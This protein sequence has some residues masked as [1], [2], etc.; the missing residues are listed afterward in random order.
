MDYRGLNSKTVFDPQPM[1]KIDDIL[2]K[3]GKAKYLTK[4]DLTQ[5]P[6]AEQA[7]PL[8]AFVTPF[9][10][11]QFQV[12]P[13]GMI[14]S[15]ASFVCLMKK[16]LEGKDD[17][18]DSFIDDTIV[19]SDTWSGR[20][21]HVKSILS[22]LRHARLTAKPS[23]SFFAFRQLEFLAHG[24][25]NGEVKPK[26]DKVKAIQDMPVPTTKRK[27]RSL[28][29]FLNF[30]R[31]FIPHFS[32]IASP[33]TDLT[34]KSA[35]NKVIW[36][37][38]HQQ[39]FD[40]LKRV[41]ITYPVLRNPDFEKKIILQTDSSDRG[42]NAV[43]LQEFNCTKLPILFISK[44]LLFR[45]RQ[46]STIEKECLA[47]VRA[48]SQLREYL[49]G[50]Q[51]IIESDHFPLQWLNKIRG[52]SQRPLRWSL[53]LQEFTFKLQHIRGKDNKIADVLSRAFEMLSNLLLINNDLSSVWWEVSNSLLPKV[54]F[55]PLFSST[56]R[57]GFFTWTA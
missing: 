46:Y 9:G 23:K 22:E 43:L 35:P 53:L 29:G 3:L 26:E 7:K 10:Q 42:I 1:P 25:G 28:I 49:E 48:V 17:F 24:V 6:L 37:D 54:L 2:N 27:V 21:D 57:I 12:M 11:Y 45:E 32:E 34:A 4:I 31:R 14:N 55:L 13:F 19:F 39:A 33:L 8:S 50:K 40:T 20:L 51:F 56:K 38:Q 47:I 36:T 44:K 18:S 30:Y 16:I 41:I 15:G 52:Q 5:I